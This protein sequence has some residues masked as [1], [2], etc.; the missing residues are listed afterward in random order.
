MKHAVWTDVT[1][2]AVP[3]ADRPVLSYNTPL[4]FQSQVRLYHRLTSLSS[5]TTHPFPFIKETK[6]T[7]TILKK[8]TGTTTKRFTVRK[9]KKINV[10]GNVKNSGIKLLREKLYTNPQV[11]RHPPWNG[12]GWVGRD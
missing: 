8:C 3:E 10:L 1:T 12:S 11:F 4:P 5:A 7:V 2:E 9:L 6:I